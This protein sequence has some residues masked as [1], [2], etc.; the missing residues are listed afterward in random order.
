MNIKPEV[1]A[2]CACVCVGEMGGW[3]VCGQENKERKKANRKTDSQPLEADRSR[4]GVRGS[5]GNGRSG[6]ICRSC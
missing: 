5:L 2:S 6:C 4:V 3:G 1:C